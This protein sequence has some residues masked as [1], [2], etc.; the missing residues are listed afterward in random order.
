MRSFASKSTSAVAHGTKMWTIAHAPPRRVQTKL[1]VGT[2]DDAHEQEAD[3]V[4]DAVMAKRAPSTQPTC[5]AGSKKI[6]RKCDACVREEVA[7]AEVEATIAAGGRPLDAATRAFFEPR[8]GHDFRRVRIHDDVRA[9]AS[10]RSVEARAYTVGRDIVFG[11]GAFAP[12]TAVG[13]RL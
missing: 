5:T 2:R 9:D 7:P 12:S 6:E 10:A 8:L 13:Q 11:A 3:A 4:A 1:A